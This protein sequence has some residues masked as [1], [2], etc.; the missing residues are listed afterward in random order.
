MR[1]PSSYLV[2]LLSVWVLVGTATTWPQSIG[3]SAAS[4]LFLAGGLALSVSVAF[5]PRPVSIPVLRP[6]RDV[7]ALVAMGCGML[8][9][10]VLAARIMDA[11]PLRYEDADMIP[12]LQV[13][14]HRFLAGD[15]R[16][17][18]DQ[19]PEIWS[20]VQP[21][22]LPF[23][24]LPF[25][26]AELFH[27]DPRWVTVAGIW[28]AAVFVLVFLDLRKGLSGWLLL[29]LLYVL[30]RHLHMEPSHNVI[31]LTEEGVVYAW[32][33]LLALAL[34]SRH[35]WL[36]GLAFAACLLSRYS[37]VGAFPAILLW[38]VLQGRWR[39]AIVLSAVPGAIIL[40][41]VLAFGW[42]AIGP[43]T[44]LPAKYIDHAR[45]VWSTNPEYMTRGLG[46][47][48]FFG[49]NHVAL[50][51][52]LLV[53]VSLLL[54]SLAALGA[55]LAGRRM[56]MSIPNMETAMVMLS[57]VAFHALVVVPYDYLFF[58]PVFFALVVT[59]MLQSGRHEGI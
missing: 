34:V 52:N 56:K 31:R 20:G 5:L 45:W 11:S 3:P 13:M 35:D 23:L 40:L 10:Y 25:T 33:A 28:V 14:A 18:Y 2:P 43:F 32:Y 48:K 19:I 9:S 7:W 21:I 41:S 8:L 30:M 47:S 16:A 58:T 37:A 50:Q 53:W 49:P 55:W 15:W 54:P 12:I 51:H 29:Y 24:W 57:L 36:L 1:S 59:A 27:F 44:S 26:A 4:L 38:R 17:M 46:L 42:G 22:Y 39:S 6:A